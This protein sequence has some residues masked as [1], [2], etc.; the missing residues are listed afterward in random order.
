MV[1]LPREEQDK[2]IAAFI[3]KYGATRLTR[4]ARLDMYSMKEA[5]IANEAEAQLLRDAGPV[6]KKEAEIKEE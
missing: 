4:D 2:M 6:H 5:E 3:E 1:N